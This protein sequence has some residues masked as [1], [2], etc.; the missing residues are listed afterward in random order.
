[1]EAQGN[2]SR[3]LPN[4]CTSADLGFGFARRGPRRGCWG[5]VSETSGNELSQTMIWIE[6]ALTKFVSP[7]VGLARNELKTRLLDLLQRHRMHV[8]V[9]VVLPVLVHVVGELDCELAMEV[10]RW[11]M[12]EGSKFEKGEILIA[13]YTDR[14]WS[15]LFPLAS[16]L[17]SEFGRLM[18]HGAVVAREY[19]IPAVVGGDRATEA[20]PD[21]ALVRVNG[22]EGYVEI[23]R[24]RGVRPA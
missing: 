23:V 21:G 16:G 10:G 11:T 2:E 9:A 3:R 15:P 1:M 4:P 20:I 7:L 19:G 14:A 12:L 24:E 5:G 13:P 17:V 18:T 22:S 6:L 8:E